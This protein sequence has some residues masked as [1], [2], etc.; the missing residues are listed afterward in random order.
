MNETNEN[1][2]K[3]AYLHYTTLH[4]EAKLMEKIV[5]KIFKEFL[6][7]IGVVYDDIKH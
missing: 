5:Q 1:L 4:S 2:R 6:I 3:V 7:N